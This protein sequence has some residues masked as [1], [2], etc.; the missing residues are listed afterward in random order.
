MQ[1]PLE[2]GVALAPYTTFKIGG[3]AKF[4]AHAETLEDLSDA[5]AWARGQG[6]PIL[7]LGGGSNML[8]ND[9]GF[10]GLVIHFANRGISVVNEDASSVTINVASGQ[11][12]DDVVQYTVDRG[13]WGVENLS[14]IPGQTASL[15]VQNVGAYGQEARQVVVSVEAFDMVE[16]QVRIFSKAECLFG[17]RKSIFNTE[18]KG[19]Y[20][21]IT[22]NIKLSKKARP[23]LS[24]GAPQKYFASAGIQNPTQAQMRRA[25][26]EIRDRLF[27][28][29]VTAVNGNTGSF[30]RG[31]ILSPPEIE[32]LYQKVG[33]NFGAEALARLHSKTDHL[34]VDQGMKTPTGFLIELCG[35]KGTSVGGAK[36][37]S[38]HAGIIVNATGKALARD[39][40]GLFTKV[41][42]IV[43]ERT[44]VILHIEPDLIGYSAA[45]KEE[46]LDSVME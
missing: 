8:V 6:V 38:Q 7:I 35:L 17:Y 10:H 33:A 1:K 37:H 43:H 15:T 22:T 19:R 31:P 39:V 21:I 36:I 14:H 9:A 3:P 12:W 29:P 30:F 23:N 28:F 44:G 13:W 11:V 40:I 25:I 24:Y 41:G 32:F 16:Q 5:V 20:V 27:P 26:T 18:E 45:E 4:F 34:L 46:I 2:H 42:R